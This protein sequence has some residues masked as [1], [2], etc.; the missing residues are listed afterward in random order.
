V[1]AGNGDCDGSYSDDSIRLLI[2]LFPTATL[3]ISAFL[4]RPRRD[5]KNSDPIPVM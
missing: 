3:Y 1:Y 2:I 4:S 5:E